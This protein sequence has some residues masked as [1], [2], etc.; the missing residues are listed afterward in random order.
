[1]LMNAVQY[2]P[3]NVGLISYWNLEAASGTRVDSGPYGYDL[4]DN[5]STGNVASVNAQMGKGSTFVAASNNYL[6]RS[7]S[8][9]ANLVQTAGFTLTT[10]VNLTSKTIQ[11]AIISKGSIG[12]ASGNYSIA[13]IQSTDRFRAAVRVSGTVTLSANNFGSPSTGTWYFICVTVS[14]PGTLSISVNNGTANTTA[15]SA[16]LT[17]STTN[18]FLIGSATDASNV[19]VAVN[20]LNG[21]VDG[22]G[23]WNRILTASE[24]ARLYAA[25]NGRQIPNL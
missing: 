21:S 9:V 19:E 3:L 10:W 16:P 18:D 7:H 2:S 12:A 6:N 15:I 20:A 5:N 11:M 22:V 17:N 4:T 24:I 25:G 1:M 14:A 13:Y 23:F 8:S